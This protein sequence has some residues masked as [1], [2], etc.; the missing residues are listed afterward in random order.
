MA[1]HTQFAGT[2]TGASLLGWDCSPRSR[3]R[4]RAVAMWIS[5]GLALAGAARAN[6]DTETRIK[7][8][9]IKVERCFARKLTELRAKDPKLPE[10]VSGFAKG[11]VFEQLQAALPKDN[12]IPALKALAATS[13]ENFCTTKVVPAYV[14]AYGKAFE[15]VKQQK[16]ADTTL[17]GLGSG[18]IESSSYFV[19]FAHN[20]FGRHTRGHYDLTLEATAAPEAG[21]KFSSTAARLVASATQSPDLYQWNNETYHAHTSEFID[22]DLQD[23]AKQIAESKKRYL[24]LLAQRLDQFQAHAGV[25]EDAEALFVLGVSAHMVQDLVYHRGMTLRQH[26]GLSYYLL[27]NPD[28]PPGQLGQQR[29]KESVD[30]TVKLFRY[31][32][33]KVSAQDWKRLAD[34]KPPETGFN[35]AEVANRIHARDQDIGTGPLTSYYL[36]M[37]AYITKAR[38][39]DEL[40]DANCAPDRGLVCWDTN[41]VLIEAFA[42]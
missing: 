13:P 33:G 21:F 7:D 15:K 28:D 37:S 42:K 27:K 41:A 17:A 16:K 14:T 36:M 6:D 25:G 29:W 19:E 30:Q 4:G 1:S 18:E 2:R 31:A 38:S 5:L 10:E 35:Y 32:Q 39:P 8:W 12:A 3:T 24:G 26:A 34:W 23:R 40:Q 22:G 11:F 9:S 20:S